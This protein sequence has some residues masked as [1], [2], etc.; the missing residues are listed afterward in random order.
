MAQSI[1][2][3]S[4]VVAWLKIIFPLTALG[5]LATL[6]LFSRSI[7]PEQS[8][9]FA[10]IDVKELA[11]EP[12]ITAPEF[13]GM[14][15]D[16]AAI[17]ISAATAKTDPSNLENA[18]IDRLEAHFQTPDG[19]EVV[20]TANMGS[21]ENAKVAR[22]EGEVL[23][24]TSSGYRI[25]TDVLISDLDETLIESQG[26]VIATGPIGEIEAG[27]MIVHL[28]NIT[29]TSMLVFKNG[30]KVLYEPTTNSEADK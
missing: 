28:Q 26:S 11:R 23:I 5:L 7:D 20:A 2:S 22:L 8:I 21:I 9:P 29:G 4:R 6:F 27:K 13:S 1:A 3:Y 16:G 15:A 12:R 18:T 30:I 10:D 17:T 14:T 25:S 24:E 19:A